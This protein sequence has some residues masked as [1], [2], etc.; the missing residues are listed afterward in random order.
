MANLFLDEFS[1]ESTVEEL[2]LEEA[3]DL[4]YEVATLEDA[5]EKVIS[6]AETFDK[7]IEAYAGLSKESET[8]ETALESIALALNADSAVVETALEGFVDGTKDVAKKTYAMVIKYIG[9]LVDLGKKLW[10]KANQFITARIK[11]EEVQKL[12]KAIGD[13][14]EFDKDK[15]V[16]IA[17]KYPILLGKV[18]VKAVIES[19]V[20]KTEAF[21]K[22]NGKALKELD[23]EY[24]GL[25]KDAVDDKKAVI[26]DFDATTVKAA[27]LLEE[28]DGD[29]K[30]VIKVKTV[31]VK[32]A[33]LK[34]IMVEFKNAPAGKLPEEAEYLKDL[35]GVKK[36]YEAATKS[37][38]ENAKIAE[39]LGK[40]GEEKLDTAREVRELA[41]AAFA[42][43]NGK[44]RYVR[45]GYDL[46]KA[47]AGAVKDADGDKDKKTPAEDKK[48]E[49]NK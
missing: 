46:L 18:D 47:T 29:K 23:L 43:A 5:A 39:G 4:G 12:Y 25:F 35:E 41:T 32:A 10:L 28:S 42:S 15:L 8:Y 1:V 26:I 9:K 40:T 33:R 49:E 16:K 36:V 27:I 6:D 7:S 14:K 45:Q 2:S 20:N 34:R 13:A 17:G 21:I 22:S 30:A 38:D 48:E 3:F 19:D 11:K 37:L 44:L 31:R 24:K